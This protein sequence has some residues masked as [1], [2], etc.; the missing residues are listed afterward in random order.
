MLRVFLGVVTGFIVW[1]AISIAGNWIILTT[2]DTYLKDL[3]FVVPLFITIVASV[4]A[5]FA[6]ASVAR[7]NTKTPL[8]LSATLL[9][10]V[11]SFQLTG[12]D[13]IELW[14]HLAFW[15]CLVPMIIL[16]GK[17]KKV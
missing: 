9:I 13:R 8:I 5:G 10:V 3:I 16:G 15:V 7:E 11:I 12:W 17:L 4:I 14:Y 1:C 2:L 6:A